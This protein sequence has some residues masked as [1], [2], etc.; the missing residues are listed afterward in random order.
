MCAARC[1]LRVPP[2]VREHSLSVGIIFVSYALHVKFLP[3]LDPVNP[4]AINPHGLKG[5]LASG[6]QLIYVRVVS[7]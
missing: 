6:V 7:E 4:E 5:A 3:F 1:R 2:F